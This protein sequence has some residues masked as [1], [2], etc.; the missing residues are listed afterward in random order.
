MSLEIDKSNTK[1]TTA[2]IVLN[3]NLHALVAEVIG[4]REAFDATSVGQ[5]I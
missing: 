4:H 5:A 2:K 1:N 3:E